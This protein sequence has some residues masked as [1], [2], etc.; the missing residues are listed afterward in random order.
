MIVA[1][2]ANDC[3]VVSFVEESAWLDRASMKSALSHFNFLKLWNLKWKSKQESRILQVCQSTR[4]FCMERR[5]LKHHWGRSPLAHVLGKCPSNSSICDLR[6]SGRVSQDAPYYIDAACLFTSSSSL[7]ILCT[8][9]LRRMMF[10][11]SLLFLYRA[12][13]YLWKATEDAEAQ[14]N[15]LPTIALVR[16]CDWHFFVFF[17]LVTL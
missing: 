6:A 11:R 10:E 13:P 14:K 2:R 1:A 12:G 4:A 7:L 9:H 15:M 5:M 17:S 3:K 16:A 8:R